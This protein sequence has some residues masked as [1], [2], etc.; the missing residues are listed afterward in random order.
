M[1]TCGVI[2]LAAG[3]STRLGSP[4]QLLP[5]QDNNL[6]QHAIQ[7]AMDVA[8][9]H[10]IVVLGANAELMEPVIKKQAVHIAYNEWW[11]KGMSTSIVCG[12][13]ALLQLEPTVDA[14]IFMVCDQPYVTPALLQQVIDTWHRSDRQIVASSYNDTIGT[15][16]LFS[17]SIFQQ[18]L[19]LKG[20]TGAKKIIAQ[21]KDVVATVSFPL[22]SIDIDSKA[23]YDNWKKSESPEVGKSARRE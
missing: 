18:L 7:T 12:L 6:L 13:N 20:D 4:K 9:G 8:A 19:S 21:N 22:G 3:N 14:A 2:L 11:E 15:P 10:I 17:A 23:D 16:A 1:K 5:L